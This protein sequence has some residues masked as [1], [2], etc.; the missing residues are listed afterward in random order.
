MSLLWLFPILWIAYTA[1]RPI[2]DTIQH[3]YVSFPQTLNLDNFVS[4]WN[5]AELPR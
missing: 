1:F 3:G 2:G 4:A 5:E